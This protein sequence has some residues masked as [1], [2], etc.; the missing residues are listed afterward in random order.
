M[1]SAPQGRTHPLYPTPLAAW[2]RLREGNARFVAGTPEHPNQDAARRTALTEAQAPFV[3]LFGCSDSRVA[4]EMIFD[5]GL[6]EMFVVRTAGQVTDGVAI[7]SLEYG[8]EALGT[9]LLIVLGHDSCGAITEAIRSFDTGQTPD[10]FITDIVARLL[11]AVV[12]ARANGREG[13]QGT[14]AQNTID[15]CHRLPQRSAILRR[16]LAEGRLVILGLTYQLDDG[17]IDLVS[18]LGAEV[19]ENGSPRETAD[20]Y[21]E[22]AGLSA[23]AR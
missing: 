6:G 23:R 22:R 10:G 17:R 16:A 12:H 15:T 5:V 21:R 4:A 14:V 13:I 11:P 2:T 7:G 8:V 18:R 1:S 20:E 19:D 9:P 3:T